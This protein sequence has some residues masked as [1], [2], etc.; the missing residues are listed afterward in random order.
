MHCQSI[1]SLVSA[2]RYVP[3]PVRYGAVDLL[4]N[5]DAVLRLKRL[6][7][8]LEAVAFFLGLVALA[9]ELLAHMEVDLRPE[10]SYRVSIDR[11]GLLRW[12]GATPDR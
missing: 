5:D 3:P 8:V 1:R 2:A 7:H 11:R 10:N 4:G 6:H 12:T 9:D